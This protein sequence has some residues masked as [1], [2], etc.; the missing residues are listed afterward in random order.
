MSGFAQARHENEAELKKEQSEPKIVKSERPKFCVHCGAPLED[1]DDFCTECGKKIEDEFVVEEEDAAQTFAPKESRPAPKI[2][3]DRM[4][5]VKETERVK[6]DG[7]ADLFK[8]AKE[9]AESARKSETA[10]SE[11]KA[12]STLKTGWYILKAN[13]RKSYLIIESVCGS[14]VS[15]TMKTSFYDGSYATSYWTGTLLGDSLSL[16]VC[17]K[18]L[19]PCPEQRWEDFTGVTT[20]THS[21]LVCDY[22]SGTVFQDRIIVNSAD[23]CETFLVFARQ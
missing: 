8:L 1:G 10:K 13:D 18:D 3:S 21:I 7:A 9:K 16:S 11:A 23:G 4:A 2:A 12:T 19:H 6:E 14:S 22:F 5:S 17:K 15:A 20:I